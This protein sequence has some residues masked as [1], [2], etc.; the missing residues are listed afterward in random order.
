MANPNPEIWGAPS[1][2]LYS[3]HTTYGLT[4]QISQTLNADRPKVANFG[5][6]S[7]LYYEGSIIRA[8]NVAQKMTLNEF[9]DTSICP[10][11]QAPDVSPFAKIA[12]FNENDDLSLTPRVF[13]IT[14]N[15]NWFFADKAAA[16]PTNNAFNFDKY[17]IKQGYTN[18]GLAW[19][20]IAPKASEPAKVSNV[21]MQL[22]PYTYYGLR[23]LVLS[24]EVRCMNKTA[25]DPI[26]NSVWR[27]LDS[28]KNNY[29]ETENIIGLRLFVRNC[30]SIN[31]NTL[32]LSYNNDYSVPDGEQ[33]FVCLLN[34]ITIN[35]DGE[36]LP[37]QLL[38]IFN[39]GYR[40][41][42]I[43]DLTDTVF[44]W[45]NGTDQRT[46]RAVLPCW[47]YFQNQTVT[48]W[49]I[50]MNDPERYYFY[51]I[52]YSDDTYNK[53]MA[54]AACFGCFFTPTNKYQFA[55]DMLDN[56]LYLTV[57]DENGV[58]H[59]QYTHGAANATNSLYSKNS[60]REID[61][62][63]NTPPTP[64]D[65]NTYSN[66]SYFKFVALGSVGNKR[67]SLGVTDVN[68]LLSD[69][70]SLLTTFSQD[71]FD[72]FTQKV[73]AGFLV[74]NPIDSIVSLLC[75]PFTIPHNGDNV[76]IKLGKYDM[77]ARGNTV[78]Q[79]TY[80]INFTGVP[81][82]PRFGDCYLDYEPYTNYEV[83]IPF[84]GTVP[85]KAADIIGH[86]LNVKLIVDL[87]TGSCTGYILADDLVIETVTGTVAITVP[88]TGMDNSTINSQI[89]NANLNYKSSQY[90][91]GAAIGSMV[92][93]SGFI[94]ALSNPAEAVNKIAQSQITEE[95]T[96]YELTHI[97]TQPHIIGASS[98]ALGWCCDTIARV[99]IYYPTGD[100]ITDSKPPSLINVKI[101][102][103]GDLN[104]FS[105]LK[106]G[107]VREFSGF[108]LGNIKLDGVPCTESERARLKQLFSTGVYL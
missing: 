46:N 106:W 43:F 26:N 66:S 77:T 81:I 84:C 107:K 32:A 93:V 25:V 79:S 6:G 3:P 28:W 86:T 17:Y 51:K 99:M 23:S 56:D 33:S 70:W 74:T 13:T 59:G 30:N 95:R 63:P 72:N 76:P 10:C 50:D 49:W 40:C 55:Y 20:Q 90:S 94:G 2:W 19:Q 5:G 54:I 48:S 18:Q 65:P 62:N 87:Y 103:F 58:A 44:N 9:I 67:Y 8:I 98:P 47:N 97:P 31:Q 57:L 80:T 71:S 83:Y 11:G 45:Y 78:S 14:D 39:K 22:C 108:T 100:V 85:L 73:Q 53:I 61:Y 60:I 64:T 36:N 89:V 42:Y 91:A 105:C 41:A 52:P 37:T 27:T 7:P 96:Q 88:I 24:I 68:G 75:F 29:S 16:T 104:G 69:L 102:S 15:I 35:N 4:S 12:I 38:N 1:S 101:K 21:N 82:F 34:P 92:S